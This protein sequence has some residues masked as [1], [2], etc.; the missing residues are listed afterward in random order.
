M[1]WLG[2]CPNHPI[3]GS[4][5]RARGSFITLLDTDCPAL[6]RL[7][8]ALWDSLGL[9]SPAG[10]GDQWAIPRSDASALVDH[11]A[12]RARDGAGSPSLGLMDDLRCVP[13]GRA[14]RGGSLYP[15]VL[16]TRLAEPPA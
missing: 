10:L 9:S 7:Y 12:G 8:G 2:L 1:G 11:N 3:Y 4:L 14:F 5:L 16:S 13:T 15:T 6:P